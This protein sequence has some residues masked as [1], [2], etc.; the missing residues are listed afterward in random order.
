ML[1]N[2]KRYSFYSYLLVIR[3]YLLLYYCWSV[4]WAQLCK[5]VL[6]T[7]SHFNRV[8]Y[9]WKERHWKIVIF[10][11]LWIFRFFWNALLKEIM[12][13]KNNAT[14]SFYCKRRQKCEENIGIECLTWREHLG[15]PN[16]EDR[17]V[18]ILQHAWYKEKYLDHDPAFQRTVKWIYF[19]FR[20]LYI[21]ICKLKSG[22]SQGISFQTLFFV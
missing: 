20:I 10:F 12:V 4:I 21:N 2:C 15:L 5:Y 7:H 11:P 13:D 14:R 16:F 9:W 1:K 17:K 22:Y 18:C 3:F 8:N 6:L 19:I